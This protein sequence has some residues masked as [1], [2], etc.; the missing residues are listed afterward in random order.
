MESLADDN[1]G[2][3]GPAGRPWWRHPAVLVGLVVA[4]VGA[5]VGLG[6]TM[7]GKSAPAPAARPPA[8]KPAAPAAARAPCPLTGAPPP[9]GSPPSRPALAVKVDNFPQARPQSGL[10]KADIVFE[11][12]VEGGVTRYVA[13]FQCQNA[14]LVGPV[15]SA[16]YPDVAILDELSHPIFIHVGGINP[17]Q[18][19]IRNADADN[20]DLYYHG[21]IVQHPPGRSAPFNTYFSTS[22]AWAANQSDTSTPQPLFTYSGV[23]AAGAP[24]TSVHIPFSGTSD[25]RWTWSAA[26]QRW[27]LSYGGAP[28]N[29][30]SGTQI[31]ATNVVIMHV[32]TTTGPWLENDVG[33][34]EV[35]VDPTSGGQLQVLRN[36][37]EIT[38]TWSRSSVS[39]P[40]ELLDASGQPLALQPGSTWVDMV[41]QSVAVTSP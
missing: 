12:P 23:A 2:P 20:Y 28:A 6:V 14:S 38:G 27:L 5:G 21:A 16:R 33:G 19:M 8:P 1:A 10:D 37:V 18:A 41:P 7:T 22:A 32:T 17:I 9:T 25:E 29:L 30:D 31:G 40:T 39:S 26:A 4:V 13:V 15:R 34:Y 36:G 3:A 24:T 11:E 35:E